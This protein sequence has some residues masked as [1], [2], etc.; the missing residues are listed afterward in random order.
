MSA[1]A[2]LEA[3]KIADIVAAIF[4]WLLGSIRQRV[5]TMVSFTLVRGGNRR[6][7]S[8]ALEMGVN[9]FKWYSFFGSLKSFSNSDGETVEG[10][11]GRRELRYGKLN[12][13]YSNK[14][15]KNVP[16][17]VFNITEGRWSLRY[18]NTDAYK[19]FMKSIGMVRYALIF[20]ESGQTNIVKFGFNSRMTSREVILNDHA[21]GKFGTSSLHGNC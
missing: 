9:C 4:A 5:V 7:T 10:D 12:P 3:E 20:H 2:T 13:I 19:A 21:I 8:V 16:Y 18:K 17:L 11:V 14:R 1:L 6:N 15:S